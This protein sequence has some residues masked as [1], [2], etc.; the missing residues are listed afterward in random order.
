MSAK[1]AA[2]TSKSITPANRKSPANGEAAKTVVISK[3]IA[4]KVAV[5]RT[6]ATH[7]IGEVAGEIWQLLSEKEA[8]TLAA[9]K[10]SIAAPAD[11]V[12]AAVG[13]L[14]REGKLEFTAS[15]KTLKISLKP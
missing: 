10:K 1:K 4:K 6:L 9:M 13:W 14:A 7:H 2:T 12:V 5:E 11:V 8:Q 15:G 3:S